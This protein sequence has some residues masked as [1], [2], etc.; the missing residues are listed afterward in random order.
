MAF[1][2]QFSKSIVDALS[3]SSTNASVAVE[4]TF[5]VLLVPD[6]V[7]A[8]I[9]S[10]PGLPAIPIALQLSPG[11]SLNGEATYNSLIDDT[12]HGRSDRSHIISSHMPSLYFSCRERPHCK[13]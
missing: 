5:Y 13:E 6:L 11:F 4:V 2:N 10:E 3:V 8:R 1:E 7:I 12:E 9:A